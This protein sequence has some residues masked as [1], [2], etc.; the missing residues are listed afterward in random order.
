MRQSRKK[1]RL[2]AD[3]RLKEAEAEILRLR[4]EVEMHE[5]SAAVR[6]REH[7]ETTK[8]LV[9]T[10]ELLSTYMGTVRR[11]G[12]DIAHLHDKVAAYEKGNLGDDAELAMLKRVVAHNQSQIAHKDELLASRSEII[13][14]LEADTARLQRHL[15]TAESR[16]REAERRATAAERAAR[17]SA[18][19]SST[20]GPGLLRLSKETWQDLIRL[21][22][23]DV[24]D[25]TA[26]R[27]VAVRVSQLVVAA[28]P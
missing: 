6:R 12:A 16:A 28:R 14:R 15:S 2:T 10:N 25:K 19:T 21:V 24:H 11:L 20:G 4:A 26:R 27:D 9:D 22:H 18:S 23:P 7:F 5:Q 1:E 17:A 3:L 8:A 13:R